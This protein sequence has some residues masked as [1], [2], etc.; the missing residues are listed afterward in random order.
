MLNRPVGTKF[1]EMLIEI[2]YIFIQENA[3]NNVVCKMAAILCRPQCVKSKIFNYNVF[4][5]LNAKSS[6][7]A[8]HVQQGNIN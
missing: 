3:F 1:S 5:I 7:I 6:D 2:S 4:P 8:T